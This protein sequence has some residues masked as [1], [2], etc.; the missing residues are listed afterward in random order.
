[1]NRDH[2]S[3]L[4]RACALALAAAGCAPVGPGPQNGRT[5]APADQARSR[6]VEFEYHFVVTDVPAGAAR[7][8]AWV[9][10]PVANAKQELLSVQVSASNGRH[11]EVR[12]DEYGNRFFRFDF[13]QAAARGLTP[14]ATLVY[15]VRRRAYRV[16]SEPGAASGAMAKL[17]E[18]VSAGSA[19]LARFLRRDALVP[20]NGRIAAEASRVAEA[21]TS[22]AGRARLLFDHIVDTVRYDKSGTGWGRGD[23]LYACDARAGNCTDFHSLFIGEARALELPARFIMGFPLPSDKE[24]GEVAGYHC[25]AE[26]YR[27]GLGWVPLDASEAHKH[28]EKREALYGGLDADRIEFTVGRDIR[29]PGAAAGSVNYMIY[30]YVE[31]DGKAHSGI[32]KRFR[33]RDVK[34]EALK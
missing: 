6:T 1:M 28:P 33:F 16:L 3:R 14:T 12:E 11:S 26:W 9:P 31:V 17:P 21:G 13:S 30:P 8:T 34:E 24:E 27:K 32:E 23:A 15:R 4:G 18:P 29:L 5:A 20:T 22:P 10:I 19:N 2:V 25:W 7:V